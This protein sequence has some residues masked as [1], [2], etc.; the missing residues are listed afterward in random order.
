MTETKIKPLQRKVIDL[1]KY[2]D[3]KRKQDTGLYDADTGDIKQISDTEGN[4]NLFT[5]DTKNS[6]NFFKLPAYINITP[7]EKPLYRFLGSVIE[8]DFTKTKYI[9]IYVL[10]KACMDTYEL[11]K[12]KLNND[13]DIVL[14]QFRKFMDI[15]DEKYPFHKNRVMSTK[16]Y[17]LRSL[18]QSRHFLDNPRLYMMTDNDIIQIE[19]NIEEMSK[20]LEILR[21]KASISSLPSPPPLVKISTP[22]DTFNDTVSKLTRDNTLETID[23]YKKK[24]KFAISLFKD[25]SKEAR[26]LTTPPPT[27]FELKTRSD[28]DIKYIDDRIKKHILDNPLKSLQVSHA[29]DLIHNETLSNT[30]A[31]SKKSKASAK[32]KAVSSVSAPVAE[33]VEAVSAP[34]ISDNPELQS[35]IA[36]LS[37]QNKKTKTMM[38]LVKKCFDFE[39]TQQE[40]KIHSPKISSVYNGYMEEVDKLYK[41]KINDTYYGAGEVFDSFDNESQKGMQFEIFIYNHEIQYF[42]GGT[43]FNVFRAAGKMM[44]NT[45]TVIPEIT[46]GI[47]PKEYQLRDATITDISTKDEEIEIKYFYDLDLEYEDLYIPVNK[48]TENSLFELFF[49]IRDEQIV[50]YNIWSRTIINGNPIGWINKGNYKKMKFIIG[51]RSGFVF[52]DYTADL[53]NQSKEASPKIKLVPIASGFGGATEDLYIVSRSSIN[54]PIAS[55]TLNGKPK[56]CVILPI[57]SYSACYI[58]KK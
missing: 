46:M 29:K 31:A 39:T 11:L 48:F 58:K 54:Y 30:A 22:K 19:P 37:P 17:I 47:Y 20:S 24:L 33:E 23:D 1:D 42:C 6:A 36:Y 45:N 21:K 9:P 8:E 44:T 18:E 43:I 2:D 52:Y 14:V 7:E 15:Y 38:D 32:K 35:I 26:S 41:I 40:L 28:E 5:K 16:D 13:R 10:R 27:K 49:C 55:R 25:K 34:R 56:D 51:H 3:E 50:L 57:G 12:K 4:I 53:T